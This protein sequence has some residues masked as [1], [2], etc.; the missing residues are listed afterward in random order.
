VTGCYAQVSPE[1][2]AAIPGVDFIVAIGE[3]RKIPEIVSAGGRGRNPDP[4]RSPGH[5]AGSRGCP[6]ALSSGRTRAYLKVQDGC[7][8]FCSYCIVLSPAGETG[9]FPGPG[10]ARASNCQRRAFKE[11]VLTGFT[12]ARTGRTL[13]PDL[14]PGTPAGPGKRARWNS[15]FA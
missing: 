2:I 5:G 7:D 6:G 9:V 15:V 14:S 8:S 12:S 11:V 4:F 1:T 3:S 10:R 13:I